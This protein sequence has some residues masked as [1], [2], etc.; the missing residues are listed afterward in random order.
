MKHPTISIITPS[1]NQGEFIE[2]TILSVLS[3]DYPCLE[4]LVMDGSSSDN[5]IMVL[6]KYSEKIKWISEPDSGQTN[7]INKGFQLTNGSIV[8]YLNADDILLPGSLWEIAKTFTNHPGTMWV[9]GKCRII[10]EKNNEIR[11]LITGYKNILRWF[12]CF[13]LVVMTNYLSQPSTFWRREVLAE[14]GFLDENLHYVMDYEYWLRLYSRYSPVFIPDYLASFKI[15][16]SS[17]TTSTGHRDVYIEEESYVIRR[18]TRSRLLLLL[19]DVHRL[20]MTWAYAFINR[21]GA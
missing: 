9:T 1:L 6:E 15:H 11:K 20:L 10:N 16:Q 3:Q 17:K 18:H 2:E 19:H 12:G 21:D 4:Y 13:S 7:A 5:T 8:G 14:A